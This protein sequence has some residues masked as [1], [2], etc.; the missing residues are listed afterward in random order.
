MTSS[1]S[2]RE[3]SGRKPPRGPPRAGAHRRAIR[4]TPT[5][6]HAVHLSS[7]AGDLSAAAASWP[8]GDERGDVG[9]PA[10]GSAGPPSL[11]SIFGRHS[12]ARPAARRL[13]AIDGGNASGPSART[14]PAHQR[15][16]ASAWPGGGERRLVA[17]VH[18]PS[19]HPQVRERPPA[20]Q[21][22]KPRCTGAST[23]GCSG[24]TCPSH[25]G[26]FGA[27]SEFVPT[28]GRLDAPAC[29]PRCRRMRARNWS[30]TSSDTTKRPALDGVRP[31]YAR[32]PS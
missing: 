9:R 28:C 25:A 2:P 11:R 6:V 21:D 32:L 24:Q 31:D 20:H 14:A 26:H 10:A 1:P 29:R 30:R 16:L 17:E 23:V 3:S 5:G 27:R 22:G 4:N 15:V 8:S 18:P 13:R 19:V 12:K 7:L